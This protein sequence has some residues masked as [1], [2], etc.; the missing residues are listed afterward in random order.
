MPK[1]IGREER[2]LKERQNLYYKRVQG[3]YLKHFEA[4]YGAKRDQH[5]A[6]EKL[7]SSSQV[8]EDGFTLSSF[9]HQMNSLI[10][11]DHD[12]MRPVPKKST[13]SAY[14]DFLTNSKLFIL[15]LVTGCSGQYS[16]SDAEATSSVCIEA[17]TATI[18]GVYDLEQ[19]KEVWLP[20]NII[21]IQ[22]EMALISQQWNT[23]YAYCNFN[24]F[25]LGFAK[26][27]GA[28]PGSRTQSST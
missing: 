8:P 25:F 24:Q 19:Y 10:Y 11:Y 14:D 27:L 20:K 9:L 23:A 18:E 6:S 16:E 26:S 28:G 15:G 13:G 3:H 12:P 21:A 7:K 1:I 22:G 4:D 2:T 5:Y 17:M